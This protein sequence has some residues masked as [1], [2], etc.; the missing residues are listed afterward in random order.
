[1]HVCLQLA[2]I[3][4][5]PFVREF[6]M[7]RQDKLIAMKRHHMMEL[8][9]HAA[10]YTR[11]LNWVPLDYVCMPDIHMWQSR[12]EIEGYSVAYFDRIAVFEAP[13]R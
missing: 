7:R 1:M 10:I 4:T 11:R 6:L 5:L 2:W 13:Y 8:S 3:V 9:R 12:V